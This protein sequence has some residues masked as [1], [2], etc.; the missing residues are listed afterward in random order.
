MNY[1]DCFSDVFERIERLGKS[2]IKVHIVKNTRIRD[3][4][5][6][7]FFSVHSSAVEK[8]KLGLYL[9][10]GWFSVGM[11]NSRAMYPNPIKKC[12]LLCQ[13]W[14]HPFDI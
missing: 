5:F 14:T 1:I 7:G 10:D 4:M 9:Y 8:G 13:I 12:K 11:N 2:R 3:K 6:F